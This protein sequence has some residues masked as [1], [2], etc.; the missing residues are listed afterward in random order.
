[1]KKV[2]L[3]AALFAAFALSLFSQSDETLFGRS[4]LRFTGA[5]GASTTNLTFFEDDFA[6]VNGGYGGLEFG[7]N[8]FIGWGGFRTANNFEIDRFDNDRFE[9][10]YNGL[11]LGYAPGSFKV[12]HPK[13]MLLTG[14]GRLKVAGENSDEIFVL[15]PSAGVEINVF[16]W[17][18]LG[19]EGGYRFVADA[20]LLNIKDADISAPFGELT[21]KFGWSWGN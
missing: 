16:K 17:F 10:R 1:M 6:I 20:D 9:M 5:W 13:F 14:G 11:M 2:F 7:K 8:V 3:S 19:L 18:R 12:L 21:F 15:Q 4:G